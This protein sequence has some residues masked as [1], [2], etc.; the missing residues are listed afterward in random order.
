MIEK[1]IKDG[2]KQTEVGIIPNDW[3][4]DK[5]K[6]ISQVIRGAS[7][8]P[9]GDKRYYGG[10]VPRLMVKDV[11]RDG[12]FVT[13]MVDFLTKEGEKR[14][15]P[16]KKG[17]L[18]IVCSGTVGIP[19]FLAKDACIHDGFLA[20]INIKKNIYVDYLYHQLSNLRT[21]FESSATHG[22]V[23]TNLTTTIMEEFIVP[24]PPEKEEQI[25]IAQILSDT[26]GLI[27]HL[28]LMIEKKKNIKQ[29]T[30]QEL[31]TGKRR[32]QD[33][34][35][36]WTTDVIKNCAK[37][38]TGSKNTQDKVE[39]GLYPF[40]VRSQKVEH[41]NTYSYDGEAVLTAG[42]GVGTGK[43]FH[44]I[45]GKF[46]FHQRVYK[47]SDFDER[48]DGYFFYIFFSNNFF[49]RIMAM[50]AKSSVDSVRMDMIA[51]MSIPLPEKNEQLVIA[52]IL[53]DMNSEI[54]ELEKNR[55]KYIML[56]KGMMQKLLTG[57]I[58]LK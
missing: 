32:L 11:T 12:K 4:T 16:C 42:D 52:Q 31:L 7:P 5:I 50:T 56:K 51:N 33:Y 3:I 22:G 2:Y 24:Y 53:S 41:I 43:V 21:I 18:T 15:R 36:A 30:M 46:D 29:G 8:R 10:D 44:Y 49:A 34:S 25:A 19:S 58:R 28:D 37:I 6:N 45:N 26:D 40:F 9:K 55:D 38:T 35:K 47:I 48:L 13:P 1:S 39:D 57:K 20:L 17:T 23:F 54:K 27:N 14:S